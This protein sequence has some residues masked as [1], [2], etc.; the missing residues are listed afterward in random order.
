MSNQREIDEESES[1]DD[2][3]AESE[4]KKKKKVKRKNKLKISKISPN[5]LNTLQL[6]DDDDDDYIGYSIT[7]RNDDHSP[8]IPMF[9]RKFLL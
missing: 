4:I 9:T 6:G 5:P 3:F 1:F 8:A 7:L 2:S